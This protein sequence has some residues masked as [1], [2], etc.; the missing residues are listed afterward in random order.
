[1]CQ[2]QIAKLEVMAVSLTVGRDVHQL[3][4]GAD[5]LLDQSTTGRE[6]A[7]ESDRAREWSV[8]KENRDRAIR[9]VR[10]TKQIRLRSIDY[11]LSLVRREDHVTHALFDEQREHLVVGGGLG[12]PERFRFTAVAIAKVGEAPKHLRQTIAFVAEWKNRVT[13]SLCNRVAVTTT[14]RSTLAIG[15]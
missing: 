10:M 11:T 9:S 7:F 6:C 5:K 12:Q 1:M 3:A 8:V 13:V 15:A 4:A 14:R 2:T